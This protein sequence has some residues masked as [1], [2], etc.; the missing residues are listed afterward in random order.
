[1]HENYQ[2]G[3]FPDRQATFINVSK[4]ALQSVNDVFLK[5]PKHKLEDFDGIHRLLYDRITSPKP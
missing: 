1:M 2:I 5:R 3:A 4:F